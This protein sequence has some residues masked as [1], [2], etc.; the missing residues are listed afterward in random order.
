[1]SIVAPA[2]GKSPAKGPKGKSPAGKAP[3]KGMPAAAAFPTDPDEAKALI[4]M[5]LQ[6][7][8]GVLE[9]QHEVM[10]EMIEQQGNDA[11]E[12]ID[13]GTV[14]LPTP[15]LDTEDED[16][17]KEMIEAMV[18]EQLEQLE[19]QMEERKAMMEEQSEKML[20]AVENGED[21]MAA[22]AAFAPPAAPA[23]AKRGVSLPSKPSA[24][25]K[26]FACCMG[27]KKKP[28]PPVVEES[29]DEESGEES[30]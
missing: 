22:A 11:I 16:E 3:S 1:M 28:P 20:E 6:D 14:E 30:D 23:P 25:S 2:K 5:Q 27:P 10:K 19:A 29:E 9:Q 24:F 13:A 7:A 4:E 8:M 26:V 17:A 15:N 18:A 12:A 21:P